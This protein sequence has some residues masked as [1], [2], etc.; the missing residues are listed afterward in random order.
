MI[1][2]AFKKTKVFDWFMLKLNSRQLKVVIR[3]IAEGVDG[4]QGGMAASKYT[5]IAKI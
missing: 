3:L 4:F 5:R 2:F 1:A